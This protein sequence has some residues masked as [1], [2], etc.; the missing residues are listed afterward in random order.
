MHAVSDATAVWSGACCTAS[1]SGSGGR[2]QWQNGIAFAYVQLGCRALM[3]GTTTAI[4]RGRGPSLSLAFAIWKGGK[5]PMVTDHDTSV[6]NPFLHRNPLER[7][8]GRCHDRCAG[9]YPLLDGPVGLG[10]FGREGAAYG[11]E[12][13]RDPA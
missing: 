7:V 2:E 9:P 1:Y 3:P 13:L 6:N 8:G 11:S 12:K 10:R 5:Q 4:L